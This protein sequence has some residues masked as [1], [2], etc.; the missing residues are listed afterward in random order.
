VQNGQR[1]FLSDYLRMLGGTTLH[2]QGTSLRMV[3][4]DF[5]LRSTYGRGEDWPIS[6]DDLEPQ[7]RE[8]EWL[9][10]VSAD[11]NDQKQHGVWFP[12]DYAYPMQQLPRSIVDQF[13]IERLTNVEVSLE[14]RSY[15]L[16][17]TGVPVARNSNPTILA[18]GTA[19]S[20]VGAVGDETGGRC[21]GNSSCTPICPVQAKYNA[22]KTLE[23]ARRGGNVEVRSQSVA[24]RLIVDAVSGKASGVEYKRYASPGSTEYALETVHAE[25]VVLAANAVEN[26][27]LLLASEVNDESGQLGRN[28]MD[29][30]YLNLFGL[31][32]QPV[33]PFRGPDLTSALDSFRDGAFRQSHAA[34]RVGLGNWG[35]AGEPAR[36]T[37]QLVADGHFGQSLRGELRDRL[38]RMVRLG[39]M[40]E[41]L[42]H[43]ENRVTIDA[44]HR[45]A[46]GNY[47]PVVAYDYDAYSLDGVA[48]IID[49]LWPAVVQAAKI[50][51]TTEALGRPAGSQ[52]VSHRGKT[53]NI[54]GS[55]HLAGTH[56][57]GN[58]PQ[59]SVVDPYLRLWQH[60]NVYAVGPGSMVTMGTSNP[61]LTS[62]ALA[63]RAADHIIATT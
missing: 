51:D 8:A 12:D 61:T 26:A 6:Y 60:D 5:N 63:L 35:W 2:W 13:F 57:M 37:M 58:R 34:F 24:S 40:I 29:H 48:A 39:A 21:Q 20:P 32:P 43:P 62:T 1:T 53:L 30:P 45:D 27:V 3:P 17:F 33:Y 16:H 41:Q 19:Y 50:E 49:A 22:L 10:G 44:G 47:R 52:S 11:V 25:T 56:R 15:A 54:A 28:L 36:T 55:G 18:N 38:T 31:A 9:I 7:Y 14:N 59:D 23:A 46:L 4:H 42:P